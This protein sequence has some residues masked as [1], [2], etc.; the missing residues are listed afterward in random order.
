MLH[1]KFCLYI[2]FH[3]FCDETKKT[4]HIRTLQYLKRTIPEF[5]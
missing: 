3:Y 4:G 2:S 1:V 5:L